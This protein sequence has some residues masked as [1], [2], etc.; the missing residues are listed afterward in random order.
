M[1]RLTRPRLTYANVIATLALFLALGGGAYAATSIPKNSVG[2]SQLKD[3]SVSARKV[4]PGS[5]LAS[6][7]KL[8][9]LPTGT[10]EPQEETGAA[11]A[12]GERGRQGPRGEAGEDGARGPRGLQGPQ[13]DPGD[14]GATGATGAR[15]PKG[16]AGKDGADG[17]DGARG[18][19]GPQG[20]RGEEG[21]VGERGP[22]GE[23]GPQGEPGE[24]GP[25]GEPGTSRTVT[26]YGEEVRIE[27]GP[28]ASFAACKPG[29][30]VTGGGYSFTRS[31]EEGTY[32]V[33]ANR[34]SVS[35]EVSEGEIEELER[36]ERLGEEGEVFGRGEAGGIF[37]YRLVPDGTSKATGWAVS[38]Q[39]AGREGIRGPV[40]RAYVECSIP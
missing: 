32:G 26:R 34:P 2:W 25:R 30:Y 33:A 9:E 4:K 16:E 17:D 1:K 10:V 36:E 12:G 39:P 22:R 40:Y 11:G 24:E 27:R 3:G 13:G 20:P 35:E 37:L 15:G 38:I 19:R 18:E 8:G 7:F 5:L 21:Q 29:E 28:L 23:R 6:D 14:D 31:A